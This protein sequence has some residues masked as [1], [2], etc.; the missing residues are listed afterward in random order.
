[1]KRTRMNTEE[2][3]MFRRYVKAGKGGHLVKMIARRFTKSEKTK[4]AIIAKYNITSMEM[5]DRYI[6]NVDHTV[7]IPLKGIGMV[8]MSY[9]YGKKRTGIS[10]VDMSKEYAKK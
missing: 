3:I 4:Y 6:E 10:M 9:K 7:N 8:D 5:Y 2:T 1:M